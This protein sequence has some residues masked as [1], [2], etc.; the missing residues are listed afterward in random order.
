M[1]KIICLGILVFFFACQKDFIVKDIKDKTLTVNAPADNTLTSSNS[2]TFWWEELDGAEKYNLQIVKPNFSAIQQLVTDTN[3]TG[4]KLTLSLTPGIYQWRIRGVNNGGNTAYQVYNLKIDSTTNLSSQIVVSTAPAS[5][6]V[7]ANKTFTFSWNPVYAADKYEIQVL[8]GPAIVIDTTTANTTYIRTISTTTTGNFSW[9]VKAINNTSVSQYNTPRTFKIDLT[10]P[11]APISLMHTN[12]S[13]PP[14]QYD[15]LKWTRF[16]T[17]TD[18]DYDS[19]Y[20]YSDV[21]LTS[22]FTSTMIANKKIRISDLVPTMPPA[23]YWWR[24]KSVDSVGNA[25]L[26]SATSSFTLIP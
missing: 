19:L 20:I 21:T 26:F 4:N 2:I 18:I 25:S 12:G 17:S 1:K 5:G 23:P 24:L 13:N 14:H 3:V 9:K 22:I 7:T 6:M 15:T 8:N 10:K 11:G 16:S